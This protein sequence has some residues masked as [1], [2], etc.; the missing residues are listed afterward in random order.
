VVLLLQEVKDVLKAVEFEMEYTL[1]PPSSVQY[2][3]ID[4]YPIMDV[5]SYSIPSAKVCQLFISAMLCFLGN[6]STPDSW[7]INSLS[8]Q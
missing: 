5:L 6:R 1:A 8:C 4:T 7:A 3:D 2:E